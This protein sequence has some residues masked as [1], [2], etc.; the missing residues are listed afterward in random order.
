MSLPETTIEELKHYL[1]FPSVSTQEAHASDLRACAQWLAGKFTSIGLESQIWETEGHPVVWAKLGSDP[2]KRTVL[3]Y[4]HYDVQPDDPLEEW[5][6][7][8]FDPTIRDGKIYARGSTDNKGQHFAHLLGTAELLAEKGQLPVNIIYIIEGEEEIGSIHLPLILR[9]YRNKLSCDVVLISDTGMAAH[10]YPTLGYA[11]RGVTA[12]ECV[13]E[14]PSQDLHSGVYGGAVANPLAAAARLIAS[15]HDAEGRVAIEGFYDEVAPLQDWEREAARQSPVTDQD[16]LD[17]TGSP[18]LFGE[19][20]FNSLERVGARPTAEVNGMG[21]GYQGQGSKTVL[22]ARAFFKLTFRLVSNQDAGK[23]LDLA[24]AHFRL[25]CPPG[26]TLKIERGHSGAPYM[27]DPMSEDGLAAQRALEKTFGRKPCLLREGGS[28]PI[29]QTF[30]EIL[31]VDCLLLALASP[32][33][34]AHS[35]NENFPLINLER[36]IELHKAVLQELADV[37]PYRGDVDPEAVKRNA[38]AC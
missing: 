25:H 33:C 14:G 36:G 34:Q 4:G 37:R 23:I 10:D 9:K 22:P 20:G 2:A 31:G 26:V 16:Y 35:P 7:A 12:L 27:V 6:S 30:R 1:R 3:V 15:L 38:S 24:E 19:P 21:G 13:V 8:P 18:A 32:D 5:V 11:L 28:I 29:L 17:Q